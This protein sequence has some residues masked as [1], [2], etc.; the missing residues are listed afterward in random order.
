MGNREMRK[1]GI[2]DKS[3]AARGSTVTVAEAEDW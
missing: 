2:E 1:W 3:V